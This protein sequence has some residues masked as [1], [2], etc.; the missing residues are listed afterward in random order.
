MSGSPLHG[1]ALSA[2]DE[3]L[4]RGPVPARAIA[5]VEQAARARA[6]GV[7]ALTGGTS[8]AVHA[9]DLA[10]GRALVLR[11]FVRPEWLAEEPDIAEREAA[12]LTLVERCAV[13][14]PRLVAVDAGGAEAGEPA[15]LMT[16]LPGMVVWRPADLD[17]F[18][19]ALAALLPAIHATPADG[20]ALPD[21]EP[22]A[23]ETR[24]PPAWSRR[25]EVW[26]RARSPSSTAPRPPASAC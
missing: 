7:R 3:E 8:S 23:L 25:P 26:E 2:D 12:A 22:Y 15:L 17:G 21:Y 24:E 4:L 14:T 18:L 11:R 10:D 5:W 13:P 1:D 20:A 19:R 6:T 16:R 9:V